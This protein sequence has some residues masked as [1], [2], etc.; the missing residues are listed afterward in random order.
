[1]DIDQ[2]YHG[3]EADDEIREFYFPQAVTAYN[4]NSINHILPYN[5]I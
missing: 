1:M 3:M 4:H 5:T 2:D